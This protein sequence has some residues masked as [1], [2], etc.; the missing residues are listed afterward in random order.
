MYGLIRILKSILSPW[1]VTE[2]VEAA[3]ARAAT[4][5]AV[6]AAAA[7]SRLSI[8]PYRIGAA[9]NRRASSSSASSALH[10]PRKTVN[11][12]RHNRSRAPCR[13]PRRSGNSDRRLT[14]STHESVP[15]TAVVISSAHTQR[16]RINKYNI[17]GSDESVMTHTQWREINSSSRGYCGGSTPNRTSEKAV[18]VTWPSSMQQ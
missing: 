18:T 5:A 8:G 12:P 9:R 10:R 2:A 4:H 6:A 11:N 13:R 7:H 3:G 16:K 17:L 1:P 15:A 14:G